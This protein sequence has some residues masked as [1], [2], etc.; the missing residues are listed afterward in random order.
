MEIGQKM[1]MPENLLLAAGVCAEAL[2]PGRFAWSRVVVRVGEVPH[3]LLWNRFASDQA[4]NQRSRVFSILVDFLKLQLP[5][6][7]HIKN[8]LADECLFGRVSSIS[9]IMASFSQTGHR[10]DG[11]SLAVCLAL[12][13]RHYEC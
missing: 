2:E 4:L 3:P 6:G 12:E 7:E 8:D 10:F 1:R 13:R 11:P 9:P 5:W